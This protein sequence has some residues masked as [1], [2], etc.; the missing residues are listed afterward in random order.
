MT[1]GNAFLRG[2]LWSLSGVAVVLSLLVFGV[3]F[4]RPY[5]TAHQP[6]MVDG[7][8]RS[9]T[10]LG[11]G[12]TGVEFQAVKV[13]DCDWRSTSW[14]MGDVGG[15]NTAAPTLHTAPPRIRGQGL[16]VWKQIIVNLPVDTILSRSFVKSKHHCHPFWET[17]SLM[18]VSPQVAAKI[19]VAP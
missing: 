12:R 1:R 19:E 4:I 11:E 14:F 18:W 16:H 5:E 8:I 9:L 3:V 7:I 10:D 2:L 17:E 13:R 15:R 6:V